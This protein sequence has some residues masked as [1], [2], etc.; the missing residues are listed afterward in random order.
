MHSV[1]SG[2]MTHPV[3]PGDRAPVPLTGLDQRVRDPLPLLYQVRVIGELRG[4]RRG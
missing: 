1:Q 4:R 2:H 3:A